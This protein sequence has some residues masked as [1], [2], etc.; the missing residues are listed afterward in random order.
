MGP[1]WYLA[2]CWLV[3]ALIAQTTVVHAFAVHNVVPSL[4][5]IVVVWYAMR[6]DTRRAALYGLIA[7]ACEDALA[8][9]TGASWTLA[10][11][12]SALAASMLSRGFFADSIPFVAAITIAATLVRSL[13]F[14]IVMALCGYPAGLAGMHFHEALFGAA[15]NA[16]LIVLAMVIARRVALR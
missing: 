13:I 9:G 15:L 4:V 3:A 14:W 10:T 8:P 5:F 7:G 2:A 1:P 11:G 16:A 6:V 12:A